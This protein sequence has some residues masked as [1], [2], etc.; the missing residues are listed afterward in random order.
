MAQGGRGPGCITS[1][2]SSGSF[3][4]TRKLSYTSSSRFEIDLAVT[5]IAVATILAVLATTLASKIFSLDLA[6]VDTL[7]W[8]SLK[9]KVGAGCPA[10]RV[11]AVPYPDTIPRTALASYPRS[12]SSYTR[13]LVERATGQ[14]TGAH[15]C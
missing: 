11:E 12:G 4:Y 7:S 2:V 1:K 9:Y 3:H 6:Q 15:D 14:S 13:S 10:E 5:R 8:E